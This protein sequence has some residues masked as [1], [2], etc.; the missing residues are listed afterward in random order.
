MSSLG[1]LA[2]FEAI[3]DPDSQYNEATVFAAAPIP[4][5]PMHFVAKDAGSHACI[6]V[7]TSSES[8]KPPPIR[9]ESIEVHFAIPCRI[10][11]QGAPVTSE[12]F[13]VIRCRNT[14]LETIKYFFWICEPIV[15]LIANVPSPRQLSTTIMRLAS[16]FQ[17]IRKPPSRHIIGLFGELYVIWRS[18][19]PAYAL[20]AWR[21][22]NSEWFDFCDGNIRLEV[23]TSST[24][25]RAH[26]FSY[27]QCNP[28]PDVDAVVVS[29]LAAQAG[30]GTKL[31]SIVMQIEARILEHQDLVV[32]LHEVLAGTLGSGLRDGLQVSFDVQI[33]DASVRF[34]DAASVPAI[35][36]YVPLHVSDVH[37]RSDLS[38]VTALT[39][40]QLIRRDPVFEKLLPSSVVSR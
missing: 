22:G 10:K 33:T 13:T 16:I 18:P 14:D 31:E 2:S 20:A 5:F 36:E 19:D 7:A 26:S 25:L 28:P 34:F 24:K 4:G 37:F 23:K 6:L 39:R 32:K 35:R 17:S 29:L 30:G 12:K 38:E 15:H 27:E 3:L 21:A 1:L 9:L 11:K 8:A 40:G